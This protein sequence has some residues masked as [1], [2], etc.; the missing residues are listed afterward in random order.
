[1]A[2]DNELN[3]TTTTTMS[4]VVISKD[5]PMLATTLE[6]LKIQVEDLSPSLERGVDVVVVDA[7]AGRLD[8]IRLAHPWV[9][10]VDFERPADVRISI[11]HQR[12]LGVATALG[13]II[14]FTDCGCVPDERWLASLTGPI[15]SGEEQMTCGWTGALGRVDPYRTGH[16]PVRYL[17]ECPTINLAFE[18]SV[19]DLVDGFDE[20]FEYGS[21]V[22]FSWRVVRAGIEIRLVQE[23]VIH[24]DW[25]TR[26]RQVKRSFAYGKARARLYYKHVFTNSDQSVHKRRLVAEDAVPLCFSAYLIGLPTALR[27]RSYL[28]LLAIPIWRNRHDRPL[29]SLVDHLVLGAGAIA[30]AVEIAREVTRY[31]TRSRSR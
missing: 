27:Y 28:L 4:I 11:P 12:N 10:W 26:R 25:G 9:S 5:E 21:D 6:H 1:M 8:H 14:V 13:D 23:A 18:R 15:L 2:E 22:D 24:H 20:S 29:L 7:S 3:G 16:T 30:G 31:P 17:P 19:Y